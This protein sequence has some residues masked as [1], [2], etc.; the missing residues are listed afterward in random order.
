MRA[1]TPENDLCCIACTHRLML[2]RHTEE[3]NVH[4][5]SAGLHLGEEP[6]LMDPGGWTV[7]TVAGAGL[8][9]FSLARGLV[10]LKC[11][12]NNEITCECSPEQVL[13]PQMQ[14]LK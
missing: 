10:D 9:V 3:I 12:S 1:L 4:T 2:G 14:P 7:R 5:P 11:C 6:S 8:I 13:E